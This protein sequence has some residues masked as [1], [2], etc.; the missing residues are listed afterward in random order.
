M[1]IIFSLTEKDDLRGNHQLHGISLVPREGMMSPGLAISKLRG[2]AEKFVMLGVVNTSD[3]MAPA[4]VVLR[5]AGNSRPWGELASQQLIFQY[6]VAASFEHCFVQI[7]ERYPAAAGVWDDWIN[8]F[9]FEEGFV[10]GWV[11][12]VE[13]NR[14]QNATDPFEYQ[15]A[16][17]DCS[18]LPR[19]SNGLPPP[20]AKEIVDISV[21]PGRWVLRDGYVEAVAPKMWLSE[22][23]WRRVGLEKKNRFQQEYSESIKA[24]VGGILKLVLQDIDFDSEVTAEEQVRLR[25]ALYGNV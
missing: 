20:V 7:E 15:L 14:W 8:P 5:R 1:K 6:G 23:F 12:D 25:S 16:G 18:H 24:L 13:Y 19:K 21:N 3:D 22:L 10:Q 2:T 17:R 4:S 9:V 11:S